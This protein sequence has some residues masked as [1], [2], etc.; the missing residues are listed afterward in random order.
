M[1]C[2]PRARFS[3]SRVLNFNPRI[4]YGMRH[5]KMVLAIFGSGFQSTHPVCDAT[6]AACGSK[7]A[8]VFQSTHPVWDATRRQGDD[9]R[10]V[11]ISIHASRMGCDHLRRTAG[12]C[13]QYFNPRIPYGMRLG[14]TDNG[15]SWTVFQS[16]HPVWDATLEYRAGEHIALISIHASRMGCDRDASRPPS[17]QPISIHASRMG[18]D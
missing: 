8:W 9:L 10:K 13:R 3:S 12:R 2:D 7:L 15:N 14:Q 4:P 1:G 18:C 5:L 11:R 6:C 17:Q 16:T